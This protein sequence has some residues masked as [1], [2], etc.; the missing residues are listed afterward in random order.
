VCAASSVSRLR[1]HSN[2]SKL[3]GNIPSCLQWLDRI[4]CSAG[5][6]RAPERCTIGHMH[7]WTST[8]ATP[9]INSAT[10]LMTSHAWLGFNPS[11]CENPHS[12]RELTLTPNPTALGS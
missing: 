3:D 8:P 12:T 5:K 7:G 10:T 1:K 2:D 9:T 11:I 6:S 4:H